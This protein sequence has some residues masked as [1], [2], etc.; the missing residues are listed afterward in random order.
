MADRSP[1]TGICEATRLAAR[2]GA[3]AGLGSCGGSPGRGQ[4]SAARW[5]PARGSAGRGGRFCGASGGLPS[6]TGAGTT[7]LSLGGSRHAQRSCRR[8]VSWP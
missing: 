7:A 3:R 1:R 5:P 2:A 6:P 4:N 8:P